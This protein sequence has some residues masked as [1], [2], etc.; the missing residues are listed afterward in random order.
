MAPTDTF[1][2]AVD[3]VAPLAKITQQRS[4]RFKSAETS[5]KLFD[6]NSITPG[7]EMMIRLNLYLQQWIDSNKLQL[8]SK[9]IYS[10]HLVPGEGEHKIMDFIRG[11]QVLGS[12]THVLY[13]MDADL[14]MLS[15]I[16]PIDNIYLMRE[17]VR[18][19]I[20]IDN[21]RT[22][23]QRQMNYRSTYLTDFVVI[24]SLIGNDFLPHPP[25]LSQIS[26]SID[27]M[28]NIYNRRKIS[29]TNQF[30]I[31]WDTFLI[32][33]EEIA[34]IEPSLI[35]KEST[36]RVTYPSEMIQ[37]AISVDDQ[38]HPVFDFDT[39]RSLWYH[40]EFNQQVVIKSKELPLDVTTDDIF[41]MGQQYLIGIGWVLRYYTNG[42]TSINLRWFY[43]YFHAPLFSDLQRVLQKLK[44]VDDYQSVE[45]QM[46]LN[47][48]YQ[49]LSVLPRKS[50]P[51]LPIEVQPLMDDTS[52]IIDYYPIVFESELD[53]KM[54]KWQSIPII[55][56]V[57][58]N[59]IFEAVATTAIFT[60]QRSLLFRKENDVIITRPSEVSML[61]TAN[62]VAEARSR[63]APKVSEKRRIVKQEKPIIQ[64]RTLDPEELQ[65]IN[66]WKA[67]PPLM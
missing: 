15:L 52:V 35:M 21:L 46:M 61:P 17:D 47:P 11:K 62:E 38:H 2:L 49:L 41:T 25:A 40:N 7:T 4:R 20:N 3:G 13:G 39:F 53:G 19:V 59:R 26:I 28:I 22:A 12:D 67:I 14:I 24:M 37:Q 16:S 32:F 48:I 51:L 50:K 29:L 8:P 56:F 6:S 9:V 65:R 66:K 5:G 18:D 45:G 64:T 57:D 60:Q 43:P 58:V 42:T 34:Q 27:T 63:G 1:I 30:G 10:S 54:A 55:P 33:L 31:K 44:T 23:L 36:R